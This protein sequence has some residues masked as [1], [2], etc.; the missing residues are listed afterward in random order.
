MHAMTKHEMN[1]RISIAFLSTI[2][3]ASG[4]GNIEMQ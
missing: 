2:G 3:P 4:T 1:A